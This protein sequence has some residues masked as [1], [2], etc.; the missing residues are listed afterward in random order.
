M[1][2]F[3]ELLQ[4]WRTARDPR[5]AGLLAELG[6]PAA[7]P[8]WGLGHV[9]ISGTTYQPLPA[10]EAALIVAASRQLRIV[11][12]VACRLRDRRIATRLGAA[13]GPYKRMNSQS[14]HGLSSSEGSDCMLYRATKYP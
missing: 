2:L 5:L 6:L 1:S 8:T 4:A 12:L 3:S 9:E 13:V 11:D 10:G 7:R 14:A